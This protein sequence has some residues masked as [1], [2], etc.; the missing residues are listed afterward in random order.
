MKTEP[1]DL[2]KKFKNDIKKERRR[3]TAIEEYREGNKARKKKKNENAL[4]ALHHHP[5]CHHQ[6]RTTCAGNVVRYNSNLLEWIEVRAN[7]SC[8]CAR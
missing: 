2:K 7:Q 5:E 6:H 8:R 3:W 1:Q 4:T